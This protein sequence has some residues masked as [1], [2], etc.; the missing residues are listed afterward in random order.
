MSGLMGLCGLDIY[1]ND[2]CAHTRV[3]WS[4]ERHPLP[5]HRRQWRV[6]RRE[7]QE[8]TMYQM[9][10]KIYAHPTIVAQLIKATGS[11]KP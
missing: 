6:V 4:V 8:P 11:T 2:L 9:G 5:K 1:A 7:A 3:T 10:R